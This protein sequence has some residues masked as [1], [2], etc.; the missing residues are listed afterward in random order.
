MTG[1]GPT[2]VAPALLAVL[3]LTSALVKLRTSSRVGLGVHTPSVLEL[4]GAGCLVVLAVS[5]RLSGPVGLWAAVAAVG[6][7]LGSSSHL[8]RRLTRRNHLRKKTEARRLEAFVRY[9]S[10]EPH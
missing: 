4:L 7:V 1:T 9:L 3:L 5:G 2:I 10:D 6:L 8:G